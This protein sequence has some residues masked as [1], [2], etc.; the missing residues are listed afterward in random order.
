MIRTF[1]SSFNLY[2][3]VYRERRRDSPHRAP[4]PFGTPDCSPTDP[5]WPS[6]EDICDAHE[7]AN[8]Y[9]NSNVRRIEISK[10]KPRQLYSNCLPETLA[11]R[12]P[13]SVQYVQS[14]K[15]SP[16]PRPPQ[17]IGCFTPSK[18]STDVEQMRESIGQVGSTAIPMQVR[19]RIDL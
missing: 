15:S 9:E 10:C 1:T 13:G 7:N 5:A 11:E 8:E 4:L 18:P 19:R 14:A 16:P 3:T 12:T 2:S 17:L 6:N